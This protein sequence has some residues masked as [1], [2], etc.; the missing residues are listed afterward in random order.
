MNGREHQRHT[1]LDKIWINIKPKNWSEIETKAE[2]FPRIKINVCFKYVFDL[3]YKVD[4]MYLDII[5]NK[6]EKC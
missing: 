3:K 4:T 2:S 1:L 5:T 6:Y